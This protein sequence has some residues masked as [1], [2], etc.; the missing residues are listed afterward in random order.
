MLTKYT[1]I[2]VREIDG[3]P[4]YYVA[5]V[6]AGNAHEA[7]EKGQEEVIQADKRDKLKIA[8]SLYTVLFVFEKHCKPTLWPF[9]NL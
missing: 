8:T 1:V 3:E 7:A 9:D 4:E 6:E 2:I 5:Y